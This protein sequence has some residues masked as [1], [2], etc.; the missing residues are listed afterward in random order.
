MENNKQKVTDKCTLCGVN[1]SK[2][3]YYMLVNKNGNPITTDYK[4]PIYWLKGKANMDAKKFK[5]N[6][7]KV[8]IQFFITVNGFNKK[9]F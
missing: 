7:V 8:K 1:S 6:I 3:E 5:A 2:K 4:L 9:S